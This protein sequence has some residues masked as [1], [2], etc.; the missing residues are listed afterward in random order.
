MKGAEHFGAKI[1]PE[2]ERMQGVLDR[3]PG[4]EQSLKSA[5]ETGRI[6]DSESLS[7]PEI[8]AILAFDREAQVAC[9]SLLA[10]EEDYGRA[11]SLER[12]LAW[13]IVDLLSA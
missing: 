12:E 7:V 8:A 5:C 10:K 2:S 3:H 13:K 11:Q 9:R 1:A 4:L 6:P